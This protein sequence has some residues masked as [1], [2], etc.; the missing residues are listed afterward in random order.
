M[1]DCA[2]VVVTFHRLQEADVHQSGAV[3]LAGRGLLHHVDAVV[4]LLPYQHRVKSAQEL[5]QVK[6]PVSVGNHYSDAVP[7]SVGDSGK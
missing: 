4:Q 2:L 3:E 5:L 7:G 6:L 1:E